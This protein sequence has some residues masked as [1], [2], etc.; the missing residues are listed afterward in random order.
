[1]VNYAHSHLTERLAQSAT[2]GSAPVGFLV[3]ILV[4]MWRN[5]LRGLSGS[6]PR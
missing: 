5:V 1:M 4:I 3:P 6:M 2:D